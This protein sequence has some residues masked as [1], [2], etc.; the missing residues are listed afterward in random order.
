MPTR[1][2][3]I[4]IEEK[5]KSID[6]GLQLTPIIGILFLELNLKTE[7]NSDVSPDTLNINSTSVPFWIDPIEPWFKEEE[8]KATDGV[9]RLERD[10]EILLPIIKLFPVPITITLP[11]IFEIKFTAF[12]NL[13]ELLKLFNNFFKPS[14]STLNE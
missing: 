5:R 1:G 7:F 6:A 10:E 12:E 2:S 8:S 3:K 13:E 4:G 11:F 14:I 9:P